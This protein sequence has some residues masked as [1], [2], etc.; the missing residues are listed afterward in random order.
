MFLPLKLIHRRYYGK[1][2]SQLD[3]IVITA[4]LHYGFYI[5]IYIWHYM[6][7]DLNKKKKLEKIYSVTTICKNNI[8]VYMYVVN[9]ILHETFWEFIDTPR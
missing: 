9:E 4:C 8:V 3:E 1:N 2:V 5:Y 6:V 7:T